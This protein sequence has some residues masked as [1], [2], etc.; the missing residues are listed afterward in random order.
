MAMYQLSDDQVATIR[1]ALRNEISTALAWQD[2]RASIDTA[3]AALSSPAAGWELLPI[4]QPLDAPDGPGDWWFEGRYKGPDANRF[5]CHYD[6]YEKNGTLCLFELEEF[7]VDILVGKWWRANPPWEQP[8]SAAD[9]QREMLAMIDELLGLTSLPEHNWG[10]NDYAQR[11]RI[12]QRY[13]ELIAQQPAPDA[14]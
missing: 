4:S 10:D 6:V 8:V 7:S 11:D 2:S 5:R 9:T 3:L 12:Q 13:G 1:I 14:P